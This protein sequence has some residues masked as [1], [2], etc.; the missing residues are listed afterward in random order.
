MR[1]PPHSVTFTSRDSPQPL[2]TSSKYSGF[3]RLTLA[4][5]ESAVDVTFVDDAFIAKLAVLGFR[6]PESVLITDELVDTIV[7][8]IGMSFRN[9]CMRMEVGRRTL[10]NA[11]LESVL[12]DFDQ[13]MCFQEEPCASPLLLKHGPVDFI[14]GSGSRHDRDAR[15]KVFVVECK[16]SID[17][18]ETHLPQWMGELTAVMNGGDFAQGALTDG[19][20]WMFATLT[21]EDPNSSASSASAAS[22]AT[23]VTKPKLILSMSPCITITRL[24]NGETDEASLRVVCQY[25]HVCFS[26]GFHKIASSPLLAPIVS[27][28]GIDDAASLLSTMTLD[29]QQ[30]AA[31]AAS[32][33]AASAGAVAASSD[34]A[35]APPSGGT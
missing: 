3:R 7:D 8:R 19:Y 30:S 25:L 6:R 33:S 4:N 5:I 1:S 23:V 11:V 32:A 2:S 20:R 29:E 18:L 13:L 31:A 17:A 15:V 16:A 10:V 22:S 26:D 27:T 34:V 9:Q 21:R 12:D 35:F 14:V 24:G 28:D